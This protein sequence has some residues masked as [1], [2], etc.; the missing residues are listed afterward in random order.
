MRYDADRKAIG[1]AAVEISCIDNA[2]SRKNNKTWMMAD[3]RK[4][5]LENRKQPPPLGRFNTAI[6]VLEA[7]VVFRI[8]VPLRHAKV[9][10]TWS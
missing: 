6:Q 3:G 1:I 7:N 5:K 8:G 10:R 2:K 4:P 9:A